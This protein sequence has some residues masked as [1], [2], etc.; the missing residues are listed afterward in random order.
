M[1]E[2]SSPSIRL[3]SPIA[4][5]R[6]AGMAEDLNLTGMRY[7]TTAAVYFVGLYLSIYDRSK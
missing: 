5:A 2:G 3:S 7:N 1:V 6:I 4:N